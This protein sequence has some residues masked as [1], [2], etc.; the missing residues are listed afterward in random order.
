MPLTFTKVTAGPVTPQSA[1]PAATPP[2]TTPP[3]RDPDPTGDRVP[4]TVTA[5]A[6]ARVASGQP[7]GAACR[8]HASARA[9]SADAR[10]RR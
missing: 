7:A 5:T 9:A 1:A 2:A 3:R 4:R 10:C 8:E 6:Q